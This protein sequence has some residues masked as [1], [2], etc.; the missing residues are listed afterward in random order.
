MNEIECESRGRISRI[1]V[2]SGQ[3]VEY[4]QTLFMVD[5]T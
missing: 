5:P 4:G 3:P 1:I 2:E